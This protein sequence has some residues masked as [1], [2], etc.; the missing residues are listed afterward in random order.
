MFAATAYELVDVIG[1]GE[2]AHEQWGALAIAFVASAITAFISVKWLLH[3]IQHH[4]FTVFAAYRVVLGLA[5]LLLVP[6]GAVTRRLVGTPSRGLGVSS[7]QLR[8]GVAAC[9]AVA[10]PNVDRAHSARSI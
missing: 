9:I 2:A 5:L 10:N 4:R 7:R 1:N 8:Q 6:S 3:Y